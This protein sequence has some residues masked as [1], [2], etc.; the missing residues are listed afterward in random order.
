MRRSIWNAAPATIK[1]KASPFQ[2][3]R[4]RT[5][6]FICWEVLLPPIHVIAPG[7]GRDAKKRMSP[8]PRVTMIARASSLAHAASDISVSAPAD[9]PCPVRTA[10]SSRCSRWF[11]P[12]C[13]NAGE[14]LSSLVST[15]R[16]PHG[17]GTPGP[18]P[19]RRQC[20][21]R[22]SDMSRLSRCYHA[23]TFSVREPQYPCALGGRPSRDH[24]HQQ[25]RDRDDLEHGHPPRAAFSSDFDR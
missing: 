10:S 25:Q 15:L 18:P 24:R 14:A 7:T 6:C 11:H 5:A 3:F 23:R 20:I 2:I 19:P 9:R 1:S 8:A 4:D 21:R 17:S 13:G 12:S 16:R 22:Q